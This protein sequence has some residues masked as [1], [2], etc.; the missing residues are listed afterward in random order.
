M[1]YF[2]YLI[3]TCNN[4]QMLK[5][6]FLIKIFSCLFPCFSHFK[7]CKKAKKKIWQILFFKYASSHVVSCILFI[8]YLLS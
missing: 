8:G 1:H 3:I 5:K 6:I 4:S 7:K 2:C